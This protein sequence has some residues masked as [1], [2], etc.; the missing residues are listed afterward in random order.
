MVGGEQAPLIICPV[1]TPAVK[2]GGGSTR[3]WFVRGCVRN[4]GRVERELNGEKPEIDYINGRGSQTPLRSSAEKS[5]RIS[6]N[7]GVK[8]V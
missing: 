5:V 2:H 6:P 1:P 4:L 8:N 3:L 7:P